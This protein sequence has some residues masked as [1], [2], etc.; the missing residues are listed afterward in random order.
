MCSSYNEGGPRVTVEAM[1]CGVPVV[2]TRVGIMNEL[3]ENGVNGYLVNWD[4]AE[5]AQRCLCFLNNPDSQYEMG[6]KGKETVL[7]L[8][9]ESVV[10]N[11]ITAFQSIIRQEKPAAQG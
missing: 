6:N 2:S 4:A 7:G 5:I 8:T 10:G 9:A 1:A 11:Y 3:I